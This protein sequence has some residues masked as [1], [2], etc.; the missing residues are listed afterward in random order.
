MTGGDVETA[1]LAAELGAA[2]TARLLRLEE[3][4][5]VLEAERP[6]I[7]AVSGPGLVDRHAD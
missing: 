2:V 3:R 6:R 7:I 1:E 5:R 4:V